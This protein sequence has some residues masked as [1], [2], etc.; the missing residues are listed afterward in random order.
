MAL[1]IGTDI[2]GTFTDVVGYDTERRAILFGKTLT[3]YRDLVEGVFEG[4]SQVDIDPRV[5]HTLKH[6]TTQVIN[7]LL[8][9]KALA[10][11]S[12]PLRDSATCSRSGARRVRCHSTLIIGVTRR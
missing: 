5:I 4:L 3:N 10:R 2:G 6:G 7:V 12:S 11:R 8:E 9:R 1:L